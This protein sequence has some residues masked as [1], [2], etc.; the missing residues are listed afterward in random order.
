MAVTKSDENIAHPVEAH[1]DS[2]K[3]NGGDPR[4][5][6]VYHSSSNDGFDSDHNEFQEGVQRVRAITTIWSKSTL[7][8]FFAL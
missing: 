3:G 6:E 7:W 8:S 2:E 1:L 4:A 5:Q